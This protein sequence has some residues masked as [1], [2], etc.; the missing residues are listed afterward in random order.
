MKIAFIVSHFPV[1]SETFILNQIV[2]L[3]DRG[4]EVDIYADQV[5]DSY[6]IHPE[7]EKY[8]LLERTYYWPQIPN[9]LWWRLFKG[10]G[11]LLANGYKDL[12]LFMR[13]LN[14]TK[15]GKQAFS[16]YLLYTATPLLKKTY[17]IIHCQFGTQ[18]FRGMA[19]RVM[20][21]P[22]S[23]LIVAFR[24]YDLS[25]MLQRKGSRVYD[26]LFQE[27]DCF[28]PNCDYLKQLVLKLGC[29]EQ[30]V[31]VHRSGIDCRRF[32]FTPRH[33][34]L[35]GRVRIVTI[36]RFVE[37]KGIEYGIRAF[38]KIAQVNQNI[39]YNIIGDGALRQKLQQ[40]IEELN[41]SEKVKLLGWKHQ[42][43]CIKILNDSHILIA[44]SVTGK[45][46]DREGIPNVLKEAM[47]MGLPV[48]STFHA[49]I[50]ELVEDGISGFLVSECDVDAT[51][52]KLGYLIE[53]PEV[54][55]EMGRAGRAHVEKYFDTHALN[56]ELV[57]IYQQLLSSEESQQL[58]QEYP[59][60]Q[61]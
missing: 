59:V 18:S 44:V 31:I 51:A 38:A 1:L 11:L 48:I 55:S 49:G 27:G 36:G 47:A 41:V 14:F 28:L 37:K 30:K 54:W 39:E 6:K 24:G 21:S 3:L 61:G 17:D 34:P 43:E 15:Y 22:G 60:S 16:L 10:M 32:F 45:D 35:D 19:F 7:V 53:H 42:E 12:R 4:Y 56:N 29:S 46:G 26:E 5:G 20:N 2:G 23:K 52:E 57:K 25:E 40:L 8:R 33:L 13:S 50:P 9:N 58:M